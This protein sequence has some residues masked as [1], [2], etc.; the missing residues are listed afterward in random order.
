MLPPS[1]YNR[2]L[3]VMLLT[4]ICCMLIELCLRNSLAA[5]WTLLEIVLGVALSQQVVSQ[6]CNLYHLSA[7]RVTMRNFP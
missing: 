6:A 1:D 5:V 4:P 2:T 7:Q 3:T